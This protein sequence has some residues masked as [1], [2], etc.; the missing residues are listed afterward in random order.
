M[1]A[2]KELES[3]PRELVRLVSPT[4]SPPRFGLNDGHEQ[5]RR[6]RDDQLV[7]RTREGAEG[8]A[9]AHLSQKLEKRASADDLPAR[10]RALVLCSLFSGLKPEQQRALAGASRF[11]TVSLGERLDVAASDFVYVLAAGA[12]RVTRALVAPGPG[13]APRAEA[14][15]PSLQWKRNR[16]PAVRPPG[17]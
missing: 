12:L 9:A 4:R 15:L 16:P 7:L 5:A 14:G 11:T 1:A 6:R 10:V 3:P 17:N 8:I 2:Q 13:R